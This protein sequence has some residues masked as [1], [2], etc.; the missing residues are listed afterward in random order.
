[1]QSASAK[2]QPWQVLPLILS[3]GITL[4]VGFTASLF[5]RP[6]IAGWY[7]SLQKPSFNPPNWL[8]APVWT[9][10]YI[11]IGIAAFLTWQKRQN[12]VYAKARNW[13]F[14]QLILNFFWSIIFFGMNSITGGLA[15]ILLLL[16][17]IM[18]TIFFFRKISTIAAWLLV[19]YLAWVSFATLLNISIFLLN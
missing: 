17:S 9:A 10:L 11:M 19:P 16:I 13:Y 12:P 1:M 15:I 3:I 5:T 6:E 4:L 14:I 7:S 18:I 2:E 8:F